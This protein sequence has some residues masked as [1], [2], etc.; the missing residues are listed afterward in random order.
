MTGGTSLDHLWSDTD[1]D[2]I[3]GGDWDDQFFG[4]DGNDAIGVDVQLVEEWQ[5]LIYAPKRGNDAV[6]GG[7]G[8]DILWALIRL[9][10]IV[11][12]ARTQAGCY[13]ISEI[14]KKESLYGDR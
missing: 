11:E 6:R 3:H 7:G 9:S 5:E 10:M 4:D 12:V 2:K 1:S 13:R 8:D 14:I